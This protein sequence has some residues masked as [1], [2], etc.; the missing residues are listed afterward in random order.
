MAVALAE[1]MAAAMALPKTISFG[2]GTVDCGCR[3]EESLIL[4]RLLF[5]FRKIFTKRSFAFFFRG[6][7]FNIPNAG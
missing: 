6:G 3:V 5:I 7:G 4:P 1:A 2:C